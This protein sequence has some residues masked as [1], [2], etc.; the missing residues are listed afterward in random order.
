M[1][2]GTMTALIECR[3]CGKPISP[4]AASCPNCGEPNG[5]AQKEAKVTKPAPQTATGC[6]AA[7]LIGLLIGGILYF[8]VV[9]L[10]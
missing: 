10:H 6:L 9:G 8:I 7:I 2:V 1:D 4:N 5:I 3:I